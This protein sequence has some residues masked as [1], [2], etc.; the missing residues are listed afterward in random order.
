V[1][2]KGKHPDGLGPRNL[3]EGLEFV[4]YEYEMLHRCASEADRLEPG[5]EQNAFI[6]SFLIHARGLLEFFYRDKPLSDGKQDLL[7]VQ[8]VPLKVWTSERPKQNTFSWREDVPDGVAKE[9]AHL[10]W[11]RLRNRGGKTTWNIPG[12][13]RD[14]RTVMMT[15]HDLLSKQSKLKTTHVQVHGDMPTFRS[16]NFTTTWG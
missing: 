3:Q 7:A 1:A 8:Y 6:E 14:L 2:K 4:G 5:C 10:S 13:L 9:I 16:V 12:I 15:F 11:R